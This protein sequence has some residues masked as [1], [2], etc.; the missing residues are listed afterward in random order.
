MFDCP[1]GEDTILALSTWQ[2]STGRIKFFKYRGLSFLSTLLGYNGQT[3]KKCC[4]NVEI[5]TGKK[6]LYFLYEPGLQSMDG[7][8]AIRKH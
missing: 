7:L 6:P 8:I 3:Y 5:W 2:L 1:A 4:R